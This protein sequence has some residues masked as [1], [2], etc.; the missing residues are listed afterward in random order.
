MESSLVT[1]T[2]G[3]ASL[4]RRSSKRPPSPVVTGLSPVPYSTT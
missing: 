1:S 2:A 3:V 4:L